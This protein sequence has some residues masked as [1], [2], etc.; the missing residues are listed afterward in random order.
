[1]NPHLHY[2][3]SGRGPALV[4]LHSGAMTG[5][6]W[7]PQLAVFSEQFRTIVP[8]QPGH[9]R[10]PL[11]G[12]R[13]QVADMGRAVLHLLDELAIEKTHLLG[14]SMGGATALWI[15]V[16]APERVDRLVLFRIG[17]YKSPAGYGGSE[18]MAD[19]DYWRRFGLERWLSR[20]H[21]PQGGPDAWQQVI[22]RVKQALDPATSDHN[23]TLQTL[24]GLKPPT[25]IVA[26]DRDPL[27]PLEQV[28]EMYRQI[29]DAGLWLLPYTT[30]ITAT[31]TWR[32]D[33]FALEVC[34]F[35][36]GRGVVR[37]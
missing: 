5:T 26:G 9:G 36:Q 22:K 4:L 6:E 17:Y 33:S 21:E 13:L 18:D 3:E 8:D 35:L 12:E 29:P 15:A 1:M 32:S 20:I 37:P 24:A 10:S 16:N 28:L 30:H 25:L 31:N 34:R 11:I 27:V 19:P 2:R 7:E 14:S 23:H